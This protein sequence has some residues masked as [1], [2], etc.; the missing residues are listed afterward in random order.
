MNKRLLTLISL[1]L[2][3]KPRVLEPHHFHE[4]IYMYGAG[5]EKTCLWGFVNNK[6]TDQPVQSWS[7]PLLFAYWK[8]SYLR[9]ATRKISIF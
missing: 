2:K 4:R 5:Q 1:L 8:V 7:A 6:C 3:K 9:F